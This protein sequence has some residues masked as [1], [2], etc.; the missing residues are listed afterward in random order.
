MSLAKIMEKHGDANPIEELFE[1]V[2]AAAYKGIESLWSAFLEL[3]DLDMVRATDTALRLLTG[4]GDYTKAM[5]LLEAIYALTEQ[6]PS[7]EFATCQ[8][9]PALAQL[10][11]E[12]FLTESGEFIF[13]VGMDEV[14]DL[15]LNEGE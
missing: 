7:K 4:T 6:E 15:M 3:G 9:Y 8:K 1:D 5:K 2:G 11:M 14:L 12:E 13:D 10:F